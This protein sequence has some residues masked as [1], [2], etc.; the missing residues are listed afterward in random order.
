MQTNTDSRPVLVT[1]ASGKTGRRVA[2][3]LEANS[4]PVR[5]AS[6]SASVPFSWSD[7]RTHAPN[8]AGCRA[9]YIVYTP[10]LSA[11]NAER[12]IKAFVE[13]AKRAGLERLVI[14]SGR[15]EPAA[16]TCE[17]IVRDSGLA[18]TVVRAAWFNQ[19]FDESDF[20]P[21]VLDGTIA[22][23][24][25]DVA[26]PLVD[27]D[28]IAEVVY[29]ALTQDGHD[30][31]VYEVTGPRAL[32][33]TEVARIISDYT[34]RTVSYVPISME[35]FKHGLAEAGVPADYIGVLEYVMSHTLDGRGIHP[36]DGV[37]RALGRPPKDFADFAAEAADTSIWNPSAPVTE[38]GAQA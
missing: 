33:F 27:A 26:E 17:H 7:H 18:W 28:D 31:E 14:L 3:L 11:P 37:Q 21:M 23:P 22:L 16:E 19:N 35:Q 29:V 5:R 9:A 1:A 32:T 8:L 15:N 38:S 12:D 25:G 10:D 20:L 34:G 24:A 36:Q 4:H 2:D 13:T 30:Q 6:R